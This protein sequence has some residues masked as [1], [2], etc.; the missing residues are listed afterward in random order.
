MAGAR[1]CFFGLVIIQSPRRTSM[2]F[3]Q[4]E[5]NALGEFLAQ[6]QTHDQQHRV[7]P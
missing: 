5:E 6:G 4:S 2:V 3:S 7:L 1:V